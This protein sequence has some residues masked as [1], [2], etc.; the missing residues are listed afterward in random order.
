MVISSQNYLA[1]PVEE[2][3]NCILKLNVKIE[4]KVIGATA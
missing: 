2:L 4:L 3:T 1:L